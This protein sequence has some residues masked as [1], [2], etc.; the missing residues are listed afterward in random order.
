MS[1]QNITS[2]SWPIKTRL[3]AVSKDAAETAPDE[4]EARWGQQYSVVI[5]IWR[6][7]WNNLS[8]YFRYP[9]SIRQVIYTTN[10]IESVYRQF[11]KLTKTKGAFL[12]KK[13]LVLSEVRNRPGIRENL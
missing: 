3:S 7:K 8:G 6:R 12:N 10:T 5:Q 11:R 13:C 1:P 9:A 2:P 4:L